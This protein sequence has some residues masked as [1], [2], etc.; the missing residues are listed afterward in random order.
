MSQIV[1]V[2]QELGLKK[3]V[4][5]VARLAVAAGAADKVHQEEVFL[6]FTSV[7]HLILYP[8][9]AFAFNWHWVM[10][11]PGNLSWSG[12]SEKITGAYGLFAFHWLHS[13]LDRQQTDLDWFI[14]QYLTW[15]WDHSHVCSLCE[16]Q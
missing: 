16:K 10:T 11:P 15:K 14:S 5:H 8:F 7:S 13:F 6:Q 9:I 2:L 3:Q 1:M 12:Y 4:A